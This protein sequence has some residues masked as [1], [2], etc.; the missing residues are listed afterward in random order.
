MPPQPP[1]PLILSL[2]LPNTTP[3]CNTSAPPHPHHTTNTQSHTTTTQPHNNGCHACGPPDPQATSV[4]SPP[5]ARAR[6]LMWLAAHPVP[7][8]RPMWRVHNRRSSLAPPVCV[9]VCV[10]VRRAATA[11]PPPTPGAPDSLCALHRK[12]GRHG[13]GQLWRASA[14]MC[15]CAPW[16]AAP[17]LR[18]HVSR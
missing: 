17:Q 4:S 7:Q 9:C 12:Q 3:A 10:R 5:C 8:P 16:C 14:T 15:V 2:A 1:P 18:P 11:Q 13:E 6:M